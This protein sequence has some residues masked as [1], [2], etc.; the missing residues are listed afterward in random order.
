MKDVKQ[1]PER[2]QSCQQDKDAEDEDTFL[3]K[4]L[5]LEYSNLPGTLLLKTF[6]ILVIFDVHGR[7]FDRPDTFRETVSGEIGQTIL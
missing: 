5:I 6:G 2:Y 1:G 7:A 4:G 3:P